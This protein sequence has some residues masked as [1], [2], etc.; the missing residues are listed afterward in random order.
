VLV[1]KDAVAEHDTRTGLNDVLGE[2]P[3]GELGGCFPD[4]G[5][6]TGIQMGEL[7]PESHQSNPAIDMSHPR[8]LS[9]PPAAGSLGISAADLFRL[10]NP[11]APHLSSFFR[12]I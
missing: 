5:L 6:Q 8:S 4:A 3:G 7:G 1:R 11:I 12:R 9:S 10:K 2:Q